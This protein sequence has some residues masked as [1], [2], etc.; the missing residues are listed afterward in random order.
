[1]SSYSQ[2]SQSKLKATYGSSADAVR[3]NLV[4]AT[5]DLGANKISMYV[6]K[7]VAA[8][9]EAICADYRA[10]I[11]AGKAKAYTFKPKS[12]GSFNWRN[13]KRADGT[14]SPNLSMHSF[15]I[16]VDFNSWNPN[17]QGKN[18]KSDIP[19]ELVKS[20]NKYGVY[21]GGD[22]SGSTYDPMHFEYA[23][24]SFKSVTNPSKPVATP[25]KP[26]VTP[27]KPATP[28]FKQYKVKITAD[29]GLNVRKSAKT[30]A[31]KVGALKKNAT[32]TVT[33]KVT[34]D[35]VK[36]NATWL[37]ISGGYIAEYYTRRM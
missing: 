32:V 13:I 17:G 28:A 1:L 10:K 15:G 37:K 20:M 21:W 22:W 16:A 36:G 14:T 8:V 12:C 33:G 2:Y 30:S 7:K 3:K 6:H 23:P 34:G 19:K 11:K 24:A 5:F 35:K 31:A 27:A 29:G 26:V 18:A 9:Y 4:K 25:A